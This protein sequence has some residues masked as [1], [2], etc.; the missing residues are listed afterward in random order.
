MDNFIKELYDLMKRYCIHRI[1]IA[2][3]NYGDEN[4]FIENHQTLI[5]GVQKYYSYIPNFILRI[6]ERNFPFY[7]RKFVTNYTSAYKE[8]LHKLLK[9]YNIDYIKMTAININGG[10]VQYGNKISMRNITIKINGEVKKIKDT[11]YKIDN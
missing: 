7:Y 2:Y 5:Y 10:V 4:D 3:R 9:K 1:Y 11:E 6:I 8:D